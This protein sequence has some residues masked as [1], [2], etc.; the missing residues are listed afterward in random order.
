MNKIYANLIFIIHSLTILIIIFGWKLP[1]MWWLYMAKLIITLISELFLGYCFLSKFEF[2]LR[3][4]INPNLNY[5]Y[6]FSSYYTYKFTNKKISDRFIS[7]SGYIFLIG[8]ILINLYF[9]YL[10]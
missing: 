8:S 4:K 6:S 10:L 3:K 1:E 5:D 9:Y 7:I 2:D